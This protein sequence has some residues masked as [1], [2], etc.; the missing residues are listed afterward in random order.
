MK[1]CNNSYA[2]WLTAMSLILIPVIKNVININKYDLY[3]CD[4]LKFA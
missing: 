4:W 3:A 2:G 1:L